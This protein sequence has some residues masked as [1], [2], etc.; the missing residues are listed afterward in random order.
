MDDRLVNVLIKQVEAAL[1]V[2]EAGG[3][4]QGANIDDRLLTDRIRDTIDAIR[5]AKI[6]EPKDDR[7]MYVAVRYRGEGGALVDGGFNLEYDWLDNDKK[8]AVLQMAM[9]A[10]IAN[11]VAMFPD[12]AEMKEFLEK[13]TELGKAGGPTWRGT[14]HEGGT[15]GNDDQAAGVDRAGESTGTDSGDR[16]E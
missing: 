9:E 10:L 1:V 6:F 7:I 4:L 13:Q 16:A 8:R 14:P 3:N 15:H 5:T 12:D 2:M 11:S